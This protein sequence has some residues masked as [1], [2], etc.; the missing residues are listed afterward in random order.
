MVAT[1]DL[2]T[3]TRGAVAGSSIFKHVDMTAAAHSMGSRTP[4]HGNK[5]SCSSI[6]LK[7]A[8]QHVQYLCNREL[9]HVG[10]EVIGIT[11]LPKA[12]RKVKFASFLLQDVSRIAAAAAGLMAQPCSC[13]SCANL[14]AS[15]RW[16]PWRKPRIAAF[17]PEIQVSESG[18]F[19]ARSLLT[20]AYRPL[21]ARQPRIWSW[22]LVATAKCIFS[23][24]SC[25]T[26]AWASSG[27]P[28]F[29]IT[30]TRPWTFEGRASR[31]C[32]VR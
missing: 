1:H 16:P 17:E 12:Q 29:K 19:L 3:K 5:I 28:V 6:F 32:R 31:G 14:I 4:A 22:T 13:N 10:K 15:F 27:W 30:A 24:S 23:A 18:S 26:K 11:T 20:L 21:A 25:S 2:Y 7:R 9:L 8:C